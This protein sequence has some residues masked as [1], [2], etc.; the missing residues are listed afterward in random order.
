M[1]WT[2]QDDLINQITNNGKADYIF[3]NHALS[4]AQVAVHGRCSPAMPVRLQQGL[5]QLLI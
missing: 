1:G 2:S 4:A 3:G 5:S